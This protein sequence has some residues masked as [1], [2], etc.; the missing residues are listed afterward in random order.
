MANEHERLCLKLQILIIIVNK[1]FL[2]TSEYSTS[3]PRPLQF[4]PV[5]IYELFFTMLSVARLYN[6]DLFDNRCR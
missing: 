2:L 3:P 6:V 5:R 1:R 4:S